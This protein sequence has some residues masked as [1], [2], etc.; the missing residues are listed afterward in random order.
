MNQIQLIFDQLVNKNKIRSNY[1]SVQYIF[2]N[3]HKVHDIQCKSEE[4]FIGLIIDH[5][6]ESSSDDD[7]SSRSEHATQTHFKLQQESHKFIQPVSNI[8]SDQLYINFSLYEIS[9]NFRTRNLLASSIVE[10]LDYN[11]KLDVE[12]DDDMYLSLIVQKSQI[13]CTEFQSF[14]SIQSM[15]LNID[16]YL[17]PLKNSMFDFYSVEIITSQFSMTKR[18]TDI[19]TSIMFQNEPDSDFLLKILGVS[20]NR[21]IYPLAQIKLKNSGLSNQKYNMPT[22]N[23]EFLL[24]VDVCKYFRSKLVQQEQQD[25]I[26]KQNESKIKKCLQ[27]L[28]PRNKF[29]IF[30]Q[31]EQLQ[32]YQSLYD[33]AEIKAKFRTDILQDKNFIFLV[34]LLNQVNTV[35]VDQYKAASQELSQMQFSLQF[36]TNQYEFRFLRED[37]LQKSAIR[38][39]LQNMSEKSAFLISSISQQNSKQYY[40]STNSEAIQQPTEI[41]Q[42][43]Y[44]P[45]LQD[46]QPISC[47]FDRHQ[48]FS[49]DNFMAQNLIFANNQVLYLKTEDSCEEIKLDY[50]K[51]TQSNQELVITAFTDKNTKIELVSWSK[52][53]VYEGLN[54]TEL[55][56]E[57][58]KCRKLLALQDTAELV[59]A[60][61]EER[62]KEEPK[63]EPEPKTEVNRSRVLRQQQSYDNLI[64]IEE[65]IPITM[66]KVLLEAKANLPPKPAQK[67]PRQSIEAKAQIRHNQSV[68]HFQPPGVMG[69]EVV[70]VEY[71]ST[72]QTIVVQMQQNLV[73]QY[74]DTAIN[75]SKVQ[76]SV[77]VQNETAPSISKEFQNK[78]D[79]LN[80]ESRQYD[81][82]VQSRGS[83][84]DSQ[85]LEEPFQLNYQKKIFIQE[86][87]FS[88]LEVDSVKISFYS[89]NVEP[90]EYSVN[91]TL[92]GGNFVNKMQQT[93]PTYGQ[94]DK[95]DPAKIQKQITKGWP[96]KLQILRKQHSTNNLMQKDNGSLE[97]SDK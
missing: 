89:Q 54:V 6:Q 92:I 70:K 21:Q 31:K 34:G 1:I 77:E 28:L 87:I 45:V 18:I 38:V 13:E 39:F 23:S 60:T 75:V 62:I 35:R 57:Y 41:F 14:Q 7:M 85:Q 84:N 94:L 50:Q 58:M 64:Q 25:L 11:E 33:V 9:D 40:I 26:I 79:R 66:K 72:P 51:F 97:Y 48:E 8:Q 4:Y 3:Q 59:L 71:E 5:D 65:P 68:P 20:F 78:I 86:T 63:S 37:S 91:K 42:N 10:I 24:F 2:K 15:Q 29:E 44:T 27:Q 93:T 22:F 16:E 12:F 81:I 52:D 36:Y 55:T 49:F 74:P 43:L 19:S 53:G 46:A 30:Y 90:S 95:F 82:L 96:Q 56:D 69:E 67:N 61:I 80:G 47:K 88:K 32:N 17:L 76:R 73:S 83:Q